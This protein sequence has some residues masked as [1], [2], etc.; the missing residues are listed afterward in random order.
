MQRFQEIFSVRGV[1]HPLVSV[2]LP[3]YNRPDGLHRTLMCITGQ[4]YENLEIIV[5]DNCSSGDETYNVVNEFM[6]RDPRIAYF[7]QEQNKGPVANFK[8]VLEQSTGEYFMWAADD[9]EWD[10][11]FIQY[12]TEEFS[13][14]GED[15]VAVMM[16]AQYFSHSGLYDFFPEGEAF[17]GSNLDDISDRLCHMLK[18]NYGNLYYSLFRRSAL[19]E[20]NTSFFSAFELVSLNEIPLLLFVSTKG[21]LM[22]LPRVGL[23]KRTTDSTYAQAKWEIQ[24][25]K[26]PN[27]CGFRYFLGLPANFQYHKL[28][29]RDI[30]SVITLLKIDKPTKRAVSNMARRI[31]WAHFLGIVMSYK[32][33]RI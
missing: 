9:D 32:R 25:G 16:E 28:A 30:Q 14:L 24:G 1:K 19:F 18:N 8:F 26:L 7:R 6:K 4:S 5:S 31:I 27:P 15:F 33:P 10:E 21:K 12:C 20:Q 29:L 22:V 3:T 13:R 2:G 17:Y 23:Y 11:H